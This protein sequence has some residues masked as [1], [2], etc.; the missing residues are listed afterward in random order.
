MV[1]L[2]KLAVLP[3]QI[4]EGMYLLTAVLVWNSVCSTDFVTVEE[5]SAAGAP[6]TVRTERSASVASLA[7]THILVG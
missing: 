7:S 4:V 5:F 6:S 1:T 2:D 3:E